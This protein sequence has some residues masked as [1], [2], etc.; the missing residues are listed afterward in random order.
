MPLMEITGGKKLRKQTGDAV[1][2]V[3]VAKNICG[4]GLDPLITTVWRYGDD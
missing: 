1:S 2:A 4:G 3:C